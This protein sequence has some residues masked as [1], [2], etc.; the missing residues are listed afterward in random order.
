MT[1]RLPVLD[2]GRGRT[3]TGRLWCYAVDDRPWCG[4]THPA[5]AYVY[6][7][8]RKN[9]RPAEHLAD[10][11]ACSRSMDMPVSSGWPAIAPT[12]GPAGVLLGAHAARLLPVPCFDEIAARGRGADA[13][14]AR[15]T[16]SRPRSAAEPPSSGGK[17]GRS[18]V[19]RSSRPCM[20]GCRFMS[21]ACPAPRIWPRPCAMRSA[22]GRA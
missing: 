6:S 7:E 17:S 14:R 16:R 5:V 18:E 2:P 20:T 15:S 1:R 22:I 13:R 11:A 12:V 19:D 4:P 21:S 3:K 10:S 8:D 9:A